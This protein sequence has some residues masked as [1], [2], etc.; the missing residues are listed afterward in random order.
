MDAEVIKTRID[1]YGKI[2]IQGIYFDVAKATI[3][4]KSEPALLQIAKY[5]KENPSVS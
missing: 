1:L 2:A 4:P 3:R 5:L